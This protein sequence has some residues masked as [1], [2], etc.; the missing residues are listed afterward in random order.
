[1]QLTSTDLLLIGLIVA[2]FFLVVL[3]VWFWVR[4]PFSLWDITQDVSE[5]ELNNAEE[6]A[7][8]SAA[9]ILPK[10]DYTEKNVKWILLYNHARAGQINPSLLRHMRRVD[11]EYLAGMDF[12]HPDL[13]EPQRKDETDKAAKARHAQVTK[14]QG[15]VSRA[16]AELH[17]RNL[18]GTTFVT[19]SA[20]LSA[21]LLGA[22]LA[23]L[24]N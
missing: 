22:I 7:R 6:A 11:L 21:G 3:L 2:I 24:R 14:L 19:V 8:A 18:W 1:M 10:L 16:K 9:K 17:L 23:S 15:N 20:V 4:D 13:T 5:E 12:P